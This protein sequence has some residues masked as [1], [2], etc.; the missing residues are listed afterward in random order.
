MTKLLV[1]L[2]GLSVSGASGAENN[3]KSMHFEFDRVL[4]S[5]SGAEMI[6][7]CGAG[8]SVF[9]IA[10]GMFSGPAL[11]WKSGIEWDELKDAEFKD[12]GVVFR[13]LGRE[14]GVPFDDLE[15]DF[16]IPVYNRQ[17][18][19]GFREAKSYL[20]KAKNEEFIPYEYTLDVINSQLS[21]TNLRAITD[22]VRL[23]SNNYQ[24]EQSKAPLSLVFDE[25][26][27]AEM[28]RKQI[29]RETVIEEV[30]ADFSE[31]KKIVTPPMAYVD[32]EYCWVKE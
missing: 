19:Y 1:F 28:R 23:D 24:K 2:L 4:E 21:S 27:R 5:Y 9:K 25:Q 20:Y 8:G 10:S 15:I 13:G 31:G 22:Y 32:K 17:V 16:D 29:A 3:R 7:T 18:G 14:G 6:F 12:A 11:F 30:I 26:E